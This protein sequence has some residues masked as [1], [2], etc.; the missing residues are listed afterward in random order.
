MHDFFL[1]VYCI[2]MKHVV[3]YWYNMNNENVIINCATHCLSVQRSLR[4][5]WSRVQPGHLSSRQ[6][7]RH[8][9]TSHCRRQRP[10]T[11]SNYA[12]QMSSKWGRKSA[13]VLRWSI[14]HCRFT[15]YECVYLSMREEISRQSL[16]KGGQRERRFLL[17][18]HHLQTLKKTASLS[19]IP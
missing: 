11:S 7:H 15:G 18:C 4:W 12:Q 1:F 14:L 3:L 8:S 2:L 5:A 13:R 17:D 10:P 9:L 19:V 6:P 16:Q